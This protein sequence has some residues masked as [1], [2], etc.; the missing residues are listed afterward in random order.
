MFLDWQ[1]V[2][3]INE[4]VGPEKVIDHELIRIQFRTDEKNKAR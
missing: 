4:T 3:N 1:F 2:A